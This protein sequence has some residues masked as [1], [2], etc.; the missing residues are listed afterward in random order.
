MPM[1]GCEVVF[2]EATAELVQA[3]IRARLGGVCPCEADQPCPMLPVDMSKFFPA[4]LH[5]NT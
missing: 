4:S 5:G 1:Y 2:D 3:E